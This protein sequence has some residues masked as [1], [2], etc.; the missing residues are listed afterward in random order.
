MNEKI[1]EVWTFTNSSTFEKVDTWC[2]SKEFSPVY[3]YVNWGWGPNKG[4]GWYYN[5]GN[6]A[7]PN[8]TEE[9]KVSLISGIRPNI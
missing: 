1:A 9:Q 4:N 3:N 7:P 6:V 2:D 8:V 5:I